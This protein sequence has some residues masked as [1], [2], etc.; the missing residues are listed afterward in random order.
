MRTYILFTLLFI[1]RPNIKAQPLATLVSEELVFDNPPFQSCHASTI[2][3]LGDG[4]IM[5]A[6]FGGEFEGHSK[7]SIWS[8]VYKNHRW[9]RPLELADGRVKDTVQHACWNP[10][11]I[12]TTSKELFLYY[13]VGP[14]PRE[15]WGMM[16]SSKDE[17]KSWSMA[18][19]LPSAMLG[20]IKNKPFQLKDGTILHP[21]STESK[22]DNRWKIH[23]EKTDK[24]S[25]G[26]TKIEVNCDTFEV[27]QPALLTYADGSLQLLSRSRQNAII[28]TRSSDSGKSWSPLSKTSVVNPNSGIDAVTLNTGLQVLIYNPGVKGKEWFN[29]RNQLRVAVSRNGDHWIDVYELE[30]QD[31]GEYS[32][33]SVIQSADGLIHIMYTYD[34]KNMKHVILRI[35]EETR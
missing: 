7:V 3:E 33:P 8:S 16:K 17:G 12:R 35:T 19:R 31:T 1:L 30:N 9:S 24:H 27:I 13:K 32:Y 2:V 20:P 4:R 28:Q 10:V 22:E 29:G 5:A 6:W 34:R 26:W 15:W 18:T 11:L 14:S 25:Q 23:V 21:S